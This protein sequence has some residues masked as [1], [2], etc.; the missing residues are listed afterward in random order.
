MMMMMVPQ[1]IAM[2]SNKWGRRAIRYRTDTDNTVQQKKKKAPL[3]D[4][5]G[6]VEQ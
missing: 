5:S 6:L 4:G 2:R 1:L 3:D